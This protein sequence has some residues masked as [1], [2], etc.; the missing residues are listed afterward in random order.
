[1]LPATISNNVPG[2][3]LSMGCDTALNALVE[4]RTPLGLLPGWPSSPGAL[5]PG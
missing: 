4:V 2:T 1:M 5:P 3:D